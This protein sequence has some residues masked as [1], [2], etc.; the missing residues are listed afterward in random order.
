MELLIAFTVSLI[1]WFAGVTMEFL[2][3]ISALYFTCIVTNTV[4]AMK[5]AIHSPENKGNRLFAIGMGLFL[6]CDIN[7]GL[8]NLSGF[9]SLPANINEFLYTMSSILMWTFYAPSQVII[10]LSVGS[11]Q[12][13]H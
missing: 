2:L 9:I 1:L 10:A 5:S 7:V 12:E 13:I 6:L 11:K 4:T 3:I 8:Y